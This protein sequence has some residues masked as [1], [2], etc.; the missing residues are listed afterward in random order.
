MRR[1]G[2]IAG[3]SGAAFGSLVTT[4]TAPPTVGYLSLGTPDTSGHL[5]AAVKRGLAEA[6]YVN[7]TVNFNLGGRTTTPINCTNLPLISFAY[8]LRSSSPRP[9]H[10][11]CSPPRG[12]Q[13]LFLL[14][15]A[16]ELIRCRSAWFRA[17]IA[18]GE[19]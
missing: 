17:S 4:Q 6:G 1:R 14:C 2:F 19:T 16:R 8:M 11:Q 18:L 7:Q 12:L 3:L 13:A 9:P 5:V 10:P 15:S